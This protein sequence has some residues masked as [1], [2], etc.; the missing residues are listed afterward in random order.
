MI[1]TTI[2]A[3]AT[4]LMASTALAQAAPAGQTVAVNGM[5]MYYEVS[6]F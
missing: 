1:R 5:D 4:T 3:L 6:G 2:T